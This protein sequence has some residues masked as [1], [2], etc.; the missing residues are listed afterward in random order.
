MPSNK[1]TEWER[2]GAVTT[3]G[4]YKHYK[5]INK[6]PIPY[7]KY[8]EILIATNI[9]F[10]RAII[11][12]GKEIRMPYMGFLSV[13]KTKNYKTPVFDYNHFNLTGEKR[14]IE[15][16]HSDGYKGKFHWKKT[17][18]NVQGKTAYTLDI[19]RD[20]SRAMAVEMKKFNGHAK[21][22]EFNGK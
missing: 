17:S 21:Y 1:G 5:S 9:E 18:C 7:E 13:R 3:P 22:T 4:L 11:E 16:E 20:N 19:A 8:R 14:C 10:M 2:K 15:N 12:D 6:N